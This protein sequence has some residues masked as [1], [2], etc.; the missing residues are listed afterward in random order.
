MGQDEDAES[1]E[2]TN[3][4]RETMEEIKNKVSMFFS[5]NHVERICCRGFIQIAT[6]PSILAAF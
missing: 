3:R 6:E 5:Q 2:K 1:T 4:E